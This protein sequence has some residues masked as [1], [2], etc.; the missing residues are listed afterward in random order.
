M[1]RMC[2]LK[3]YLE[4]NKGKELVAKEVALVSKEDERIRLQGIDLKDIMIV[5]NAYIS[6]VDT[7]NS[8]LILKR[9]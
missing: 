9:R 5:D 2:L 3:V 7:L 8:S 1:V 4:D 6:M